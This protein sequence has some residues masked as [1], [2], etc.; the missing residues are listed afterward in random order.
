MWI[1]TMFWFLSTWS[2]LGTSQSNKTDSKK[3]LI[4]IGAHSLHCIDL[5][6]KIVQKEKEKQLF[7]VIL[8]PAPH[9]CH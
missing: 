7:F 5:F 8:Q 6:V 3:H 9:G 4:H 1:Q 2:K